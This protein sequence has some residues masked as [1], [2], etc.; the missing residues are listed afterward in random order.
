M[1]IRAL[2]RS[3]RRFANGPVVW[4][5][6]KKEIIPNALNKSIGNLMPGAQHME[7]INSGVLQ[8]RPTYYSIC[9]LHGLVDRFM[10]RAS[11]RHSVLLVYRLSDGMLSF[12]TAVLLVLIAWD[13]FES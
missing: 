10:N 7:D 3:L 2:K 8:G 6:A 5:Q 1:E 4:Q 12:V 9:A 11:Y 13:G